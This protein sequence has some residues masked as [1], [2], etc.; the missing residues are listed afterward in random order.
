MT[1]DEQLCQQLEEAIEAYVDGELEPPVSSRLE[2]HL[3]SCRGCRQEVAR[4][5][6][7]RESLRSLP[8]LEAPRPAVAAVLE[9]ARAEAA[10]RKWSWL[11]FLSP[12]PVLAGLAA[13]ALLVV[14]VLALFPGRSDETRVAMDDPAV[15]RAT[16]EAKLA[17]A[18]FARA[19][20]K[21]GLELG[22]DVVRQRIVLPATRVVSRSLASGAAGDVQEI[23]MGGDVNER[24]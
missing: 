5:H 1:A 18:H 17:L 23:H 12:R 9:T 11:G 4:A 22:D 13:A 8:G 3:E 21:I 24:G 15:A 14:I 19:N 6:R 7:L 16:L 20:R 2:G 10:S